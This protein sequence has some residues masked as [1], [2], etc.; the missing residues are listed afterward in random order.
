MVGLSALLVGGGVV[1]RGADRGV[2]DSVVVERA[3]MPTAAAG[4]SLSSSWYCTGTS[5]ADAATTATVV[6]VNAGSRPVRGTIRAVP[7]QGQAASAPVTL[8]AHSTLALVLA[9][10]APG[11]AAAL[12]DVDGGEVAAEMVVRR[13]DQNGVN[14]AEVT[15]CASSASDRWYFP[16][17]STAKDATLLLSLFN[18]FPE[19]AI[20]DLSFVTDQGR[21][22]P[23]AFQGLVV[24]GG[25]VLVTDV[26]QH[27]RRRASI[28]T[29]VVA[30]AGRV[31][32][33]Q[34]QSR[35]AP[36]LSGLSSALGAPSL[37]TAWFFADGINAPGLVER[38]TVSNPDAREANILVEV[39]VDEGVVEPLE[40]AVPGH[41]Q[42]QLVLDEQAGVPAG[43]PH[44]TTVRSLDGVPVV[45]TR[46]TEGVAPS[47]RVGRADTLGA[48]RVARNWAFAAGN[49]EGV[50]EWIEVANGG[51]EPA[52]ITVAM[53]ADGRETPLAGLSGLE[54]QGGRR[55]AL[56]LSQSG[57]PPGRSVVVRSTRPVV[58]ERALY[59]V[60]APGLSAS[61]GIP[62]D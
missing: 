23:A 57:L 10:I 41:S 31:V 19:D 50:E 55:V 16:D 20:V 59:R 54:L 14:D 4:G 7:P 26:G 36:G 1:D 62:L 18:P 13:A 53:V 21:A 3:L 48:R 60:G 30:R 58:A 25:G 52:R 46:A 11:A 2:A 32:A 24:P 6:L 42:L 12:V 5:P 51:T 29:E 38:F 35:S 56:L 47:P 33:A 37:G 40:R 34:H 43:T 44:A 45:V 17:G 15:P 9:D 28:A 61:V 22:V 49:P 39:D 27:V 8:A